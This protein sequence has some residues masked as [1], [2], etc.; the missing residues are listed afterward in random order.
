[1]VQTDLT[2]MQHNAP[3]IRPSFEQ[4]LHAWKD[5]LHQR[6]LAAEPLWIFEENLCYEKDPTS[7][8]GFRLGFQTRFTPPPLNAER[9]AY[10]HFTDFGA[11]LVFYQVGSFQGKSVC[12][13]LCDEWFENKGESE[14]FVR[15]DEW[16]ASFRPGKPEDQVEEVTDRQRWEK[17]LVRDRPL[18]DLDFCMTLRAIHETL[19]HGRV[20]TAYERYALRV[21]HLWGR[22]LRHPH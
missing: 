17:R 9:I 16:L 14:G 4:A 5:L 8:T 22:F 1:M 2:P 19:A 7:P 6:G 3:Y 11:R 20:L 21:M 10:D 13:M 15:R 18:H 12:L